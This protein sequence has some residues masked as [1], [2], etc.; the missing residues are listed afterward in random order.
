MNILC[1]A[2]TD[3]G[4]VGMYNIQLVEKNVYKA[5]LR[6]FTGNKLSFPGMLLLRRDTDNWL[7]YPEGY[8]GIVDCLITELEKLL[9]TRG[10]NN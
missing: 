1:S 2:E 4:Q 6:K 10:Y 3:S 8:N 7:S 9:P 5:T